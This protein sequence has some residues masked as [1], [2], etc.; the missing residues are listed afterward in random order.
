MPTTGW[1]YLH[2]NGDLLY[3]RNMDGGEAADFRE[4]SF[5]RQFWP[6]DINDRESA[7]QILI[8]ASAL[9]ADVGR[10][11]ELA[12][13]WKC[14][15]ADAQRYAEAVGVDLFLDGSAWCAR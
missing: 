4:S 8:E 11:K 2:D 9:G 6:I 3:K 14:D 12:A 5:V 10:I 13:L 1:Y 7:W 15:D